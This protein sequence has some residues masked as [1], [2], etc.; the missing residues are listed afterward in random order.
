M[1]EQNVI[2][3][4]IAAEILGI[5]KE[6]VRQLVVKGKLEGFKLGREWAIYRS[7]VMA[8]KKERDLRLSLRKQANN[9]DK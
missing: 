3:T 9:E 1:T 8:Y 2:G 6:A 5:T 4:Q 7:S